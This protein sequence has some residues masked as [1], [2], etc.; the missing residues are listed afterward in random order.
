MT[1]AGYNKGWTD[2]KSLWERRKRGIGFSKNR[3]GPGGGR[4]SGKLRFKGGPKN[5][6]GF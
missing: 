1:G 2:E 5:A 6:D 3:I 4:L